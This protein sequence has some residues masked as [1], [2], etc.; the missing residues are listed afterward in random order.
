MTAPQMQNPKAAPQVQ[1]PETAP[2]AHPKTA[3]CGPP[4]G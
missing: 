1:N 3:P 2:Q 4:P